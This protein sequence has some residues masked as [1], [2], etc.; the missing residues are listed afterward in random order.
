MFGRHKSE[1]IRQLASLSNALKDIKLNNYKGEI[2]LNHNYSINL[3]DETLAKRVVDDI[4]IE[5]RKVI[6]HRIE[7]VDAEI[8]ELVNDE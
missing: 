7:K 2:K 8:K 5:I 3:Y 4:N 1:Q 6:Q